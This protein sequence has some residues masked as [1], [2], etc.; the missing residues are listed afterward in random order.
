MTIG[1]ILQRNRAML[2]NNNNNSST[3]AAAAAAAA[4]VVV[5]KVKVNV[6]LYSASS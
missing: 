3:A 6:D 2:C 1:F 4:A 5:L